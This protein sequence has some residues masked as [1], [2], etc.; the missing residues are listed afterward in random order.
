MTFYSKFSDYKGK[1][2]G[3][4]ITVRNAQG[5]DTNV[6]MSGNPCVI[7]TSSSKLFDP[8]KSRSCSLEIVSGDWHFQ[9]YEPESRGTTVKIYEYDESYQNNVKQV[10]F[11]GYITPAS[12]D[13]TWTY[14]DTI[15]LEAVDAISTTKDFKW[16]SDGTYKTFLDIIL[17]IL[18][19][20]TINGYQGNLY[21]PRTYTY[22]NDTHYAWGDDV[23]G[24][25]MS[26]SGNF[27][28]DDDEHTPWT[29]YEILE[30]ILKFLGWSLVPDGDNVW[31]IDYRAEGEQSEIDYTV[32]DI[33][34]GTKSNQVYTSED[35]TTNL[36]LDVLAP[37]TTSVSIDD[38]YNKIEIS[39][40]L[41]KI[42]EI[43]PD[44][45]D[46]GNHIS[47]TDEKNLGDGGSQWTKTKTTKWLFW[48]YYDTSA[49]TEV[50][51]PIGYDYQTF[52][53]LKP[54]SGWT[55]HF[56]RHSDLSHE[57]TDAENGQNYFDLATYNNNNW[58]YKTGKVNTYLNTHGCLV[59][60]YAHVGNLG[61]NELP[62]TLDWDDILTFF[63]LGPTSPTR[64]PSHLLELEKNV[65]EYN[66]NEEVQWKPSSGASWFV[67]KG[68][69]FV[70]TGGTYDKKKKRQTLS[71][72]NTNDNGENY[73]TTCPVDK[74]VDGLPSDREYTGMY[75]SRKDSPDQYGLGFSM[76]KMQMEIT[77]GSDKYYWVES[78]NSSLNKWEGY[79]IKNPTSGTTTTFYLRYNNDPDVSDK[80]KKDMEFIPEYKWM[81]IV[82]NMDY[83]DKV[84]E[85]G[86][87]IKIDSED[88]DAPTKGTLKLTVFT[89]C[90][91]PFEYIAL[92]S[93]FEDSVWNAGQTYGFTSDLSPVIYCK[94]FELK[95]VYTDTQVWWDNHDNTNKSD[96]V[97]TGKINDN[98]V[99]TFD[100]IQMKLNTTQQDQPIS[101]SYVITKLPHPTEQD[102]FIYPYLA[103]MKHQCSADDKEQ[104]FNVVDA[105][106]DHHSERKPIIEANVHGYQHP[107]S[108]YS[109]NYVDGTFVLDSQSWNVREDNNRIKIIAF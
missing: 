33:R 10:I 52:C 109:K 93:L 45:F 6:T 28:D 51:D 87:C 13:Q 81:N 64:T 30:E 29:H 17:S 47:V 70:Q 14:K 35:G 44:I 103:T 38:V 1:I 46:D 75:R 37:G 11:R 12:Y 18:Q 92:M 85:D 56:Y 42:D 79:W 84:G 57:I 40:N 73:Y 54:E 36:N 39:D 68:D 102:K 43:S 16:V 41:Y 20:D 60:H 99:K 27:I 86:Y 9:L 59:Q 31:L 69:L 26:S 58:N 72:I 21:V 24:K 61:V 100:T 74:A 67:I 15:T 80:A 3:V 5:A 98:Y 89:P 83:K 65:L 48:N 104:E 49:S 78:F 90:V 55:H 105:Y 63:V 91:F 22:I 82:N 71:I 4:E 108:K 96:R 95:Y 32:Y 2:Y 19:S 107:L 23:L 50:S 34:T 77:D 88:D 62:T 8:I 66:I 53:R 97:Y 94:G 7:E 106:L 25:L 76:W 101:R